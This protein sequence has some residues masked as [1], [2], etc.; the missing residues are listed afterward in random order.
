MND[1][2]VP[3]YDVEADMLIYR[4][5]AGNEIRREK[6]NV[7]GASVS[8]SP[9]PYHHHPMTSHDRNP[10]QR[11]VYPLQQNR[12]SLFCIEEGFKNLW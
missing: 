9:L 12:R 7:T 2:D 5:L 10:S 4:D 3:E 6:F 1:P 8:L 11:V